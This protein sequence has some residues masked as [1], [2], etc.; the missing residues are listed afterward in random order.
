MM[1]DLVAVAVAFSEGGT[2]YFLAYGRVFGAVD[3]DALEAVVL[4]A[5]KQ[6]DYGGKPLTATVC[7]TLHDASSQPYFFE[8]LFEMARGAVSPESRSYR[9]WKRRMAQ[10]MSE[11]REI[12][13]LGHPA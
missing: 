1:E 4:K 12:W 13:F 8:A 3:Y 5:A 2:R 10:K 9:R 11:G 6:S 7:K